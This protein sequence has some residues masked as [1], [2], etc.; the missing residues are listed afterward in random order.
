MFEDLTGNRDR[1]HRICMGKRKLS[2]A[3]EPLISFVDYILYK[4]N[5]LGILFLF[6][7]R[8]FFYWGLKLPVIN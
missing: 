3:Y 1:A 2:L 6:Y 8:Y 4:A 5:F 7:I